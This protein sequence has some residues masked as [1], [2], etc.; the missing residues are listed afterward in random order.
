MKAIVDYTTQDHQ[1]RQWLMLD[2]FDEKN[3]ATC[4][5]CDVC[6]TKKKKENLAE[7]KDYENQILYLLRRK[8]MTVDELEN[9]VKPDDRELML[10]VVREMVDENK[11][12]YDE[13]W[14]LRKTPA[15]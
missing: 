9:E 7:L 3:Y 15:K 6:L 5:I 2:Y 1:C 11:I 13:H 12:T 4:G 10:E 8:P 14:V